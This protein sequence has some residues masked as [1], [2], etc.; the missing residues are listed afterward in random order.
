M[1]SDNSQYINDNTQSTKSIALSVTCT[2]I[3]ITMLL[4]GS[5]SS[6]WLLRLTLIVWLVHATLS[7]VRR[8]MD[9]KITQPTWFQDTKFSLGLLALEL[10]SSPAQVEMKNYTNTSAGALNPDLS[11]L[12]ESTA[13]RKA[14]LRIARVLV[15]TGTLLM[16]IGGV[17]DNTLRGELSPSQFYQECWREDITLRSSAK[18]QVSFGFRCL[19]E[20]CV[21]IYEDGFLRRATQST[22]KYFHQQVWKPICE[23]FQ[24]RVK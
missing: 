24:P 7:Q 17:R 14:A 11:G 13:F 22:I 8:S 23:S 21:F 15:F 2:L 9:Y 3:L 18:E 4:S 19:T 1:N 10:K 5:D 6:S 20:S 16:R 12:W